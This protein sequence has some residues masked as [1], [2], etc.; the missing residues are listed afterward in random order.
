MRRQEDDAP[1][2]LLRRDD[3]FQPD[4]FAHPAEHLVI[5]SSPYPRQLRD[6]FARFGD[7]GGQHV[8]VLCFIGRQPGLAQI[9][10]G[11]RGILRGG[12]I[13]Q[14]PEQRA[15]AVQNVQRQQPKQA[16]KGFEEEGEHV[17]PVCYN[18][19]PN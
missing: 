17:N 6:A 11:A 10:P 3:V 4:A 9:F 15:E 13:S 19:R 14:P 8:P 18:A 1:A 7:G 5:G 2:A 16:E 12:R